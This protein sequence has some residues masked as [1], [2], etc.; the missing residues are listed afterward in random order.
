MTNQGKAFEKT[1]DDEKLKAPLEK[2]RRAVPTTRVYEFPTTALDHLG[3]PLY[4]VAVWTDDAIYY[5]GFGY[6]AGETGAKTGAWGEV[7]ES[8]YAV[9]TLGKTERVFASYNELK[10]QNQ[11]AIEPP[12]LCLDAGGDYSPDKR[13]QWVAVADLRGGDT[14]VPIESVA[15]YPAQVPEIADGEWLYRPITNGLGAG[16]S[17]AQAIAHG[18]LETVQ[19]DGNCVTFRALDLGQ[20]IELDAVKN[21]E[22]L[23]LLELLERENIEIIPKLA[24][25]VA[26]IPVIY[27][28]GYDR[29]LSQVEFSMTVSACGEAA[30]PDREIAL[31]KALREYVSGRARKHFMHGTLDKLAR[32]APAEYVRAMT[33]EPAPQQE[34]R[35]LAA[36]LDWATAAHE[37]IF[38]RIEKPILETRSV[39]KFSELPTVE[40]ASGDW[41]AIL[42]HLQ[43]QFAEQLDTEILYADFSQNAPEGIFVAR[44][45]VPRMEGETM[46][47]GRI[48]RRNLERLLERQAADE[49]IEKMVGFGDDAPPSQALKIHLNEADAA[50]YPNAWLDPEAVARQVGEFYALY[51]EPESFAVGRVLR[52]R[53]TEAVE[54]ENAAGE[55]K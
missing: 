42:A 19:R 52:D 39:V 37:E 20:R 29:D 16:A 21:P 2:F 54:I 50:R 45:V 34:S 13:I 14:L 26:D 27:V 35:A 11:N 23:E 5:D 33:S 6:G 32:V 44:A 9:E 43:K 47:Y 38:R 8:F 17:L 40:F 12:T 28:V 36:V 53:E 41:D 7:L 46:S 18:A 31:N 49:S 25:I 10:A 48:G 55:G 1:A 22:T 24:G 30:H 4:C 51:R 15:V 3:V